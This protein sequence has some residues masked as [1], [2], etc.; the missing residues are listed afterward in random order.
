MYGHRIQSNGTV[1]SIV[2]LL[3]NYCSN[4]SIEYEVTKSRL[5]QTRTRIR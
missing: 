4:Y 2:N 1:F 3:I 5:G